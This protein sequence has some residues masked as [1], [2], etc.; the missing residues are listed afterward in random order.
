MICQSQAGP[1]GPDAKKGA[2]RKNF[3]GAL[4]KGEMFY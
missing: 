1:E 2:L 4:P 3:K